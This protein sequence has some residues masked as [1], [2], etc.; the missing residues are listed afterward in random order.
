MKL[1]SHS[2]AKK[3][4]KINGK[5]KKFLQKAGK[6]HLLT[7]KSRRQKNFNSKGAPVDYT[8][9]QRLNRLLPNN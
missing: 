7:N 2:G 6:R 8:D 3:R 4:V 5:G 1:K 9:L